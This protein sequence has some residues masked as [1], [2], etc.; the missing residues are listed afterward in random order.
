MIYCD[1]I[2][3]YLQ[4]TKDFPEKVSDEVHDLINNICIP[5]LNRNDIIFDKKTYENCIKY[6]EKN[7]YKLFP[8][9]KFIY[10]FVFMLFLILSL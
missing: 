7:Y 4:F 2:Q 1:E 10:A 8:Y 3:E 9:Q 6:C 5:T